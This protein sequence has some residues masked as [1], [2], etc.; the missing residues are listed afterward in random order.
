M[1][2]PMVTVTVTSQRF[3]AKGASSASAPGDGNVDLHWTLEQRAFDSLP[4]S[5]KIDDETARRLLAVR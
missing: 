1:S 4:F 3:G 2:A 5:V